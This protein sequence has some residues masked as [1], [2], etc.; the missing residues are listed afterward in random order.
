MKVRIYTTVLFSYLV[1]YYH[2]WYIAELAEVQILYRNQILNSSSFIFKASN[3]VS[4]PLDTTTDDKN[5]NKMLDIIYTPHKIL[6]DRIKIINRKKSLDDLIGL[7]ISVYSQENYY[8]QFR[9]RIKSALRSYNF[10]ISQPVN[11][12]AHHE[13]LYKPVDSGLFYGNIAPPLSEWKTLLPEN[14][15]GVLH[16]WLR[17][18]SSGALRGYFFHEHY[19]KY[20]DPPH[21]AG[22]DH[23][24]IT[25]DTFLFTVNGSQPDKIEH[26]NCGGIFSHQLNIYD[27]TM[28]SVVIEVK[29]WNSYIV[30]PLRLCMDHHSN[31]KQDDARIMNVLTYDTDGHK[32][33]SHAAVM[34]SAI[35]RHAL[36]HRC[37]LNIVVVNEEIIFSMA[38]GSALKALV[39]EGFIVLLTKPTQLSH[40]RGHRLY[41]QLVYY[42]LALLSHSGESAWI[43]FFDQDEFLSIE[44][45]ALAH[46]GN[47][48]MAGSSFNVM[49]FN[50]LAVK[51][52]TCPAVH[53]N[54]E[55]DASFEDN[56]WA[57]MYE[58]SGVKVAVRT[59]VG[60]LTG[61]HS[62]V[63]K[64]FHS[65]SQNTVL[66]H[67]KHFYGIGIDRAYGS[68]STG[69]SFTVEKVLQHLYVC[70]ATRIDVG[71]R[72]AV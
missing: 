16:A 38:N 45:T 41:W 7:T 61:V 23:I 58:E 72:L 29:K 27:R 5:F 18:D 60:G 24:S 26:N 21:W 46:L 43:F 57:I 1:D 22:F 55:V 69:S 30:F 65:H 71:E 2:A 19:D 4:N 66:L 63:G 64:C 31:K 37:A 50:R 35:V 59:D 3:F 67:F 33:L 8:L 48:M 51:C 34:S 49:D 39:D 36:F 32:N 10:Y 6:F 42:N 11:N 12:Q 44:D 9:S 54:G 62:A 52:T 14:E 13:G 25:S 68:R 28:A 40:T 20:N 70:D 17:C 56:S 15:I 53:I 47:V